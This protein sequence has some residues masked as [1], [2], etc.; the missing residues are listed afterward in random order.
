VSA[1][2]ELDLDWFL[3]NVVVPSGIDR[4]PVGP[5]RAWQGRWNG[6]AQ[7]LLAQTADASLGAAVVQ[8]LEQGFVITLEQA[9]GHGL[10]DADLRRVVRRGQWTS[11]GAGVLAVLPRAAGRS[12]DEHIARRHAHALAAVAAVLR[13]PHSIVGGA[14]AAVLHG[15]PLLE[16]PELPELEVRHQTTT[17]RRP[18]AWIRL[19]AHPPEDDDRWFGAPVAPITAA[20]GAVARRDPRSG[21]MAADAALH[22]KLMTAS[23]VE[24]L[25]GKLRG[26][27][28]SRRAVEVLSLADSRIESPL[29]S[30]THLALY[31]SGFPRPE[32][33]TWLRGADG[34][35]YRVDF[36]WADFGIVLEADGKGKYGGDALWAEKRRE[37]A[38]TRAGFS[39]VRVR[40]ADLGDGWPAVAAWL[41]ELMAQTR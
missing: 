16:V 29:E 40:W 33:Q 39:V 7:Q 12:A 10:R 26:T 36:F 8:A 15:L 38:L 24:L 32:P 41:S 4:Q 13:R 2:D 22:E 20:I 31:D 37:I 35:W 19:S 28:G 5:V 17:G 6:L 25:R 27:R 23:Q 34:K 30:L 9:R 11:L 3:D 1:A 21:L 18:A 14:S